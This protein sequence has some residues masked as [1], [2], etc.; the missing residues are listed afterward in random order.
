MGF[1]QITRIPVGADLSAFA[2][3]FS[4][5]LNLL[6]RIIGPSVDVMMSAFKSYSA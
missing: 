2:G 1:K 5:P 6:N 3:C 4:I